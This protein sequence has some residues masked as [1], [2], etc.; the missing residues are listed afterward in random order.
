MGFPATFEPLSV[1]VICV[2]GPWTYVTAALAA[3]AAA[4]SV[5][6]TVA[7]PTVV[8]DVSVAV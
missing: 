7:L 1:S 6:V 8:G 3:R 4:S 5:P 2:A